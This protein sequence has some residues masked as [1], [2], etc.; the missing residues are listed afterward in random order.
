MTNKYFGTVNKLA[1]SHGLNNFLDLGYNLGYN[2]TGTGNGD[3]IYTAA[4]GAGLSDK[5]G[6][7][8]E[9]FGEYSDFKEFTSNLDSGITYLVEDNVQLDFS[10]GIGLNQK[11]NYFSFGFSWNISC[12]HNKNG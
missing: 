1:I 3:L 9:T 8:L 11:M 5:L 10:A 4:I 12:N 6:M 2:Y 7:Y